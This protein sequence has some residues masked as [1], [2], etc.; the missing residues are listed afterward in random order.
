MLYLVLHATLTTWHLPT[1]EEWEEMINSLG[2]SGIAGGKMK[3]TTRWLAPNT[4][5]TNYSGF[6]AFG[7]D[8]RNYDGVVFWMPGSLT[9][10]WASTEFDALTA[11]GTRLVNDRQ[12]FRVYEFGV[13][14][15]YGYCVRCLK[16]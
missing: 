7:V 4:G 10:Y 12:D 5:A 13:N 14:K 3:S 1:K 2:G 11:I 15:T 8:Y 16:D 6:T 9:S